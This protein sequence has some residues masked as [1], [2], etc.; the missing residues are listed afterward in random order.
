MILVH[1]LDNCRDIHN[2]GAGMPRVPY[3]PVVPTRTADHER[4]R[5]F[6]IKTARK[7][8]I[9]DPLRRTLAIRFTGQAPHRCFPIRG[10]KVHGRGDIGVPA[11]PGHQKSAAE[12]AHTLGR[13]TK[14]RKENDVAID[15][16]EAILMREI[17]RGVENRGKILGAVLVTLHLRNV[18]DT[19]IAGGLRG[20]LFITE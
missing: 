19:E 7:N 13:K 2:A 6:V 17:L 14:I 3:Q 9:V 12:C 4:R 15:I 10:V 1:C 8:K 20:A 5:I 11:L 16:A 18:A